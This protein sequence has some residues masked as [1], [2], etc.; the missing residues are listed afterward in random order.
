M[1]E[2]ILTVI[3]V[4]FNNNIKKLSKVSY[5]KLIDI[6]Y[7]YYTQEGPYKNFLTINLKPS[8]GKGDWKVN[9]NFLSANQTDGHGKVVG[10]VHRGYKK[11]IDKYWKKIEQDIRTILKENKFIKNKFIVSG[12][13][14]GAGEALLLIPYLQELGTV[15]LCGSLEPPKVCDKNYARYLKNNFNT[16][17]Y[18]FSYKN[19]IVTGIPPWFEHVIKPLQIGKRFLGLS[20]KDHIYSTTHERVYYDEFRRE[21]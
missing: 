3:D 17:I 1:N 7:G 6:Q 15:V 11:E 19:D 13:S 8:H 10:K 20:F 9:F 12:R 16:L 21:G 5:D 2:N 14:K 18:E 4:A